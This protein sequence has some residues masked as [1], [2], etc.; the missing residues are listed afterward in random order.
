[1]PL[2]AQRGAEIPYVRVLAD[3]TGGD[4]EALGAGAAPRRRTVSGSTTWPV[5][6][7]GAG[8]WSHRRYHEAVE[9]AW[10]RNAGDVAA[11]ATDL[12][13]T[14]GAELIV[15][16]GDVRA[17]GLVTERLPA[18]W[19]RRVVVAEGGSSDDVLDDTTFIA[20]ADEADRRDQE[21]MDRYRAQDTPVRGLAAV[22]AALQRAQVDTVLIVDDPSSTD[23][24]WIGPDDATSIAL[25]ERQL[26]QTGVN[27]PERV[28]ADAALLRAI[29]GTDA[30]L[31]LV[32][33]DEVPLEH[34][35]G[36]LLRYADASTRTG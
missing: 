11:A 22:V 18:R 8:G 1:M 15:I 35:I 10:K 5:H 14:V 6:K 3:R 26:R 23:T 21:V 31:V 30:S 13:E 20:V 12:A 7:A 4:L 17:V 29:V 36:A 34:G 2:V 33:P 19:Q 27:A 16:G 32:G 24:L 9:E 28:R 25:D